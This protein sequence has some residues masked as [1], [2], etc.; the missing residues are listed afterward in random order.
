MKIYI[1]IDKLERKNI[2]V[3]RDKDKALRLVKNMNDTFKQR[4]AHDE[5][6]RIQYMVSI[7]DDIL[8]YQVEEWSMKFGKAPPQ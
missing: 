2:N 5:E 3:L 4:V 7:S 8:R 1:I 6:F